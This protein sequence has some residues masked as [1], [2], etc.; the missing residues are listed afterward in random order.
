MF[1]FIDESGSPSVRIS[2][3]DFLVVCLTIFR[4]KMVRD[5]AKQK[6]VDLR[7]TL[8]LSDNYEFHRVRN[9]SISICKN[10]SFA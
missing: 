10:S 1:C 3:N 5:C 7:R 6:L 8:E 2:N 9:L 4:D